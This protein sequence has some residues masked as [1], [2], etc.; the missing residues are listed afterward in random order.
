MELTSPS[1]LHTVAPNIDDEISKS[2]YEIGSLYT[3]SYVTRTLFQ[4]DRKIEKLKAKP[5]KV[6]IIYFIITIIIKYTF[7]YK[8]V[9]IIFYLFSANTQS[10]FWK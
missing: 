10:S 3:S 2:R 4:F 8:K 1:K 6:L 9:L 7:Y 5:I